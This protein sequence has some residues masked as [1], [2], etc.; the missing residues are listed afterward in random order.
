MEEVQCA[1]DGGPNPTIAESRYRRAV[2]Y[3]KAGLFLEAAALYKRNI[4]D[5]AANPGKV[6]Q[7]GLPPCMVWCGKDQ[8]KPPHRV[9]GSS[10]D[11][12]MMDARVKKRQAVPS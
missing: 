2:R 3:E 6:I 1:L 12:E 8:Q 5:D 9:R 11:K 7:P 4:D 10:R